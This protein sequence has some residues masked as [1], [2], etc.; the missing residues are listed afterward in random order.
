MHIF[1]TVKN[2]LVL[3]LMTYRLS[4]VIESKYCNKGG[5]DDE[6]YLDLDKQ[7]EDQEWNGSDEFVKSTLAT[8][9]MESSLLRTFFL[10]LFFF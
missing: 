4:V 2:S 8:T 10:L 5:K 1:F 7:A 3:L 9:V 6:E